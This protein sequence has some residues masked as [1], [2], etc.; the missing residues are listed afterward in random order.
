MIRVSCGNS[1][2]PALRETRFFHKAP[3]HGP[4]CQ[5][6]LVRLD[7]LL[8]RKA[9]TFN[10]G[11]LFGACCSGKVSAVR[12]K[13]VLVRLASLAS[14]GRPHRVNW[15]TKEADLRPTQQKGQQRTDGEDSLCTGAHG[16]IIAWRRRARTRTQTGTHSS[17]SMNGT[18]ED[19]SSGC[20]CCWLGSPPLHSWLIRGPTDSLQSLLVPAI[21]DPLTQRPLTPLTVTLG[22]RRSRAHL[23][24]PKIQKSNPTWAGE[25]G[26]RQGT[27]RSCLHEPWA[28]V[29]EMEGPGTCTGSGSG[30]V[31]AVELA[32]RYAV[33]GASAVSTLCSARWG[34]RLESGLCGCIEN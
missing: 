18:D 3:V 32:S 20:C 25:S 26:G 29:D 5:P 14:A 6:L 16:S 15:T 21:I 23:R 33:P 9:I 22:F 11:L 28:R 10:R 4:G 7:F 30:V 2:R 1:L 13:V 8:G 27:S 19:G 34:A 12:W 24:R 31:P 17:L